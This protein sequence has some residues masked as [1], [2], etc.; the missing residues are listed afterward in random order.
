M[1]KNYPVQSFLLITKLINVI[2]PY[3]ANEQNKGTDTAEELHTL[4]NGSQV[5][6]VPII[7]LLYCDPSDAITLTY[8]WASQE[9]N[10]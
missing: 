8:D 7:L 3:V 2:M 6:R 5:E 4:I 1:K 10:H 9:L